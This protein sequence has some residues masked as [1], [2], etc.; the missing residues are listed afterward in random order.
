MKA[1]FAF[2]NTT[3][4]V[5]KIRPE[6][7]SG[8]YR[9]IVFTFTSLTAVQIYDFHIFTFVY[10]PLHGFTWN[11]HSDQLPVGLLAQLVEQS[12]QEARIA[13][14][15][16]SSNSYASFVLSTGNFLR[17]SYLDERTLTYEPIVK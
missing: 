16:A 6:K 5:V 8:L 4:A 7:N 11:Q 15:Y 10:S 12:T 2:M 17:A 3:W 13:L 14:G 9:K 1:I